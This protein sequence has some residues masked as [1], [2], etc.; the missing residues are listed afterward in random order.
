MDYR[1][2]GVTH[3]ILSGWPKLQEMVNFGRQVIPLVRAMEACEQMHPTPK[4]N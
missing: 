2:I 4:V 1:R 3:F